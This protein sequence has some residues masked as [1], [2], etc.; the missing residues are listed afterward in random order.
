MRNLNMAE[1]PWHH[2]NAVRLRHGV[3][4]NP[5]LLDTNDLFVACLVLSSQACGPS[6][7]LCKR[8]TLGHEHVLD[9]L[10]VNLTRHRRRGQLDSRVDI[11]FGV[12]VHHRVN[13][14]V[15][16][17]SPIAETTRLGFVMKTVSS[18]LV[19]KAGIG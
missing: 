9:S 11:I 12:L 2:A 7:V 15:T 5:S 13:A 19:G 3:G 4:R 10:R 16:T 17:V 14:D 8:S 1:S 18:T 6:H